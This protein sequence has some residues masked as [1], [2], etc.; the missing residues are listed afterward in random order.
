MYGLKQ[1]NIKNNRS[2]IL[3]EFEM[4]PYHEHD[5]SLLFSLCSIVANKLPP[6]RSVLDELLEFTLGRS[7][8]SRIRQ[9]CLCL[10]PPQPCQAFLLMSPPNQPDS[11]AGFTGLHF[12]S[13]SP[14]PPSPTPTCLHHQTSGKPLFGQLL[15]QRHWGCSICLDHSPHL[16]HHKN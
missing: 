4:S 15:Q 1:N 9:F 5:S 7:R 3:W 12:F 11:L 6:S 8:L 14:P 16:V 13:S 2:N 10:H